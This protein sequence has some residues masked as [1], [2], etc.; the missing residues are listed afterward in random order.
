MTI[1]VGSARARVWSRTGA[2]LPLDLL[3][4][5]QF[6]QNPI[7]R[8]KPPGNV[9]STVNVVVTPAPATKSTHTGLLSTLGFGRLGGMILPG[10]NSVPCRFVFQPGI[11]TSQSW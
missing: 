10:T 1:P 6:F 5:A 3:Q 8:A 4:E 7:V 9:L 2:C 11:T